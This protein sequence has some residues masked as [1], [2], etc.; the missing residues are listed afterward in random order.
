MSLSAAGQKFAL[1]LGKA[2]DPQ[3]M[4][5]QPNHAVRITGSVLGA[6]ERPVLIRL[7]RALPQWVTPDSL[8]LLGLAGAAV[9]F[10]GYCLCTWDIRFVWLAS[11]GLF[12]NWFGDSLDGTLAR[13]RLAERPRYGFL[14]DHIADLASQILI[15]LGAGA[16]SLVHLDVACL[17]LVVF[18]SFAVFSFMKTAVP[19]ELQI[20]YGGVGPTE[21]RCFLI[22]V[23]AL[24]FWC[25]PGAIVV[26]WEPMSAVDLLVLAAS[27]VEALLLVFV[28]VRT[29]LRLEPDEPVL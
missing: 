24:L 23:N 18:L 25:R 11:A 4:T 16:S 6:L 28:A 3:S 20:S 1:W 8:T 7:A 26:L 9:T 21:V 29:V 12:I 2:V 10:I 17:A 27:A 22:A 13:V 15:G 19:G 5:D 14:V